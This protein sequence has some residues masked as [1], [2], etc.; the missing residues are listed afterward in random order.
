MVVDCQ[1]WG[2][3]VWWFGLPESDMGLSQEVHLILTLVWI[4][5]ETLVGR[6]VLMATTQVG[7][8][9][10]THTHT[11]TSWVLCLGCQCISSKLHDW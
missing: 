5:R 1:L 6:K 8:H 3:E 7:L 4:P 10:H 9:T 2:P 11:H